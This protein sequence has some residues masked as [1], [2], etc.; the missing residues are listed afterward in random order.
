MELEKVTSD[1]FYE[2]ARCNIDSKSKD[3]MCPCPR[4]SCEAEHYQTYEMK[5]ISEYYGERITER[6]RVPL[7]NH[8]KE[9]LII[10]DH[11][12]AHE[13]SKRAYALH[14]LFQSDSALVQNLNA[15]IDT[16]PQVLILIMEYRSVANYYLSH[17]IIQSNEEIVLS[18]LKMVNDMLIADK[19][20]NYKDFEKY[21]KD[22]HPRSVELNY[23][24][25]RWIE[26][27]QIDYPKL[28]SLI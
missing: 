12:G 6:S 23:Y 24:F 27:L 10:L 28:K 16:I 13:W 18:P 4:G 5:T 15:G 26:R 2:C 7:I 17:R 20:Q 3:Q 11:I 25:S 14:P 22:T 9:G 19:V 21:H 1:V 8:I